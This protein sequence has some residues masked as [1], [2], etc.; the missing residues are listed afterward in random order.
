M[1]AMFAL[2]LIGAY[3]VGAIPA[4]Y[5]VARWRRGIDIRKYGSGNVGASNVAAVVSRRWTIPVTIFDVGKGALTVWLGGLAGLSAMQ[6]MAV[7]VATVAGHNWPVFIHFRGG[8]GIFTTLGIVFV[9]SLKLGI[10]EAV[11]CFSLIPIGQLALGVFFGLLSLPV[12]SWFATAPLGIADREAVTI[13]L[14]LLAFIALSRRLMVRRNWL[15]ESLPLGEVLL[16]RLLLDRDIRDRKAWVNRRPPGEESA[17][18][19]ETAG[20]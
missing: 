3:L 18:E 9:F 20:K 6:Q 13:G 12:L 5:L 2:F 17:K 14:A 10:I 1:I 16:N 4:A 8:R 7:G 11:V 15:S 19:Q